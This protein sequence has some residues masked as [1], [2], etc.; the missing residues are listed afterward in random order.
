MFTTLKGKNNKLNARK[1]MCFRKLFVIVIKPENK[2]IW[3]L[4]IN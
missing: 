3:N 1:N 4:F 2:I